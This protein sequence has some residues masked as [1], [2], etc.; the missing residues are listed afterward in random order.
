[1]EIILKRKAYLKLKYYIDLCPNEIGGLGKS[2][3]RRM[4][5][6]EIKIVVDDIIIFEQENTPTHTSPS[7][8]MMAKATKELMDKNEPLKQWDIW[9]HSHAKID[10][11]FSKP[12]EQTIEDHQLTK[13]YLISI[14]GNKAGKF[15][16]RVDV[17]LKKVSEF[18][19][20]LNYTEEADVTIETFDDEKLMEHCMNE[21]DL[22]VT[23]P[24][25]I[26]TVGFKTDFVRNIWNEQDEKY[27]KKDK[28]NNKKFNDEY[29]KD[30]K[31][32][33]L[34]YNGKYFAR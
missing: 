13:D 4:P 25:P 30:F 28:K 8:I 2:H 24:E 22:K 18:K 11:F 16:A 15:K 3:R 27:N 14:V 32:D 29:K 34:N 31:K 23:E 26:K 9:W 7:Q 21:I 20:D 1:M 6:G 17:F 5:N 12:V 10:A 33:F 19:F